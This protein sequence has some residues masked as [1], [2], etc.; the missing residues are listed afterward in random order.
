VEVSVQEVWK[1][2]SVSDELKNFE[3][4]AAGALQQL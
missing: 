3:A 4:R 2:F 1:C